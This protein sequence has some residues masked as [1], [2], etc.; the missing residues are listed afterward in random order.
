MNLR[1]IPRAAAGGDIKGLRWAGDRVLGQSPSVDRAE[2]DARAVAGTVLG[3]DEMRKDAGRRRV[4]AQERSRAQA[5]REEA[6]QRVEQADREAQERKRDAE[7]AR[8]TAHQP[9]AE[10]E[11]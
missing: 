9:A 2:A 4:A 6:N 7:P 10:R 11:R 3:D 5:L 1:A 8:Q